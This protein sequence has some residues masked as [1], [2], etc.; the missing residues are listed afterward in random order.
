[1]AALLEKGIGK[2]TSKS[3][4]RWL[5]AK[6]SDKTSIL[7]NT[8][9]E[10]GEQCNERKKKAFYDSSET[11]KIPRKEPKMHSECEEHDYFTKVHKRRH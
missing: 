9:Q 8:Q 7:F 3:L 1:M 11:H 4:I 2:L 5:G 10:S 6:S